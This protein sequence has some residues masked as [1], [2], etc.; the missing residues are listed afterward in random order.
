MS[1]KRTRTP[2]KNVER[3]D[4]SKWWQGT[5]CGDQHQRK[6]NKKRILEGK[7]DWRIASC[8]TIVVC[9]EN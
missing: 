6:Q 2:K 7:K 5:F 3:H 4:R 9:N 8:C 1:S